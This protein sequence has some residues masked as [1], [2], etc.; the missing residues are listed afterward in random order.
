MAKIVETPLMKQYFEIKAQHPDAILLFRVG[1]FYEMYGND[2]VIGAEILG[3]VQTK[4]ANG[5]G[6]FVEMAGFPHHA[7]DSYL[8]K[9]VRAGKRVAICDQ[10]EDPKLTK[11]LVKR[12]ITELVTPGVSINDNILN[13]KENNFL[14]A[15]HFE[16]KQC[17][18]AF[19]DISTGEF[20]TAEGTSDYID[21]LLNNFSPKEVLIERNNKKLFEELFGPRF[22]TYEMDDWIFTSDAANDRLLKHFETKNLKGFGVQHLRLGIIASG[23]ILYY[24]D[25]TQHTHISH[26]ISLSRI[27]EERYVRLDKFTVR[28]LE[29]VC[30]MSE[31]GKSL[32]D[33]I[34][35]TISP[36][37]SRMLRRWMLFPLKDV[38]PIQERLDVVEYFFREPQLKEV[39]DTQLEQIGDLERI[40]SK[41]A[42]GR[43]SPREVV[44]LKVALRAVEII[45]RV[46]EESNEPTLCRI[47][48]QLNVC[49]LIRDRIDKEINNDPPSLINKGGVIANGV[50]AELDELRSIAYSGKDYLLQ[51]QQREIEKT[52]I[53]SLKIAFN[54]VF[55]Y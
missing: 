5:V 15:I 50:N 4:R 54:N 6:Q 22:L 27:E 38:K 31:E 26:I 17:G 51:I 39:F 2:A 9:L 34:D 28:S 41:V 14:A 10:L 42:V 1:D 13:H 40:I 49:A 55:G 7:L 8:P 37:G 32:L 35:K 48:E 23:A 53:P 11:K 43:V 44:Q 25:Q 33:V 29:L 45:K 30:A 3:I 21:K 18:I 12:G 19:L 20:L 46:C 16:K 47:G 36:M 24:L 52:G